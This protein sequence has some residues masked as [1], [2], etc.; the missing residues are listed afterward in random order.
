MAK[1]NK[2]SKGQRNQIKSIRRATR[3]DDTN[4]ESQK[5]LVAVRQQA[6]TGR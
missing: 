3:Q 6:R 1:S 4:R 2:L 5:N